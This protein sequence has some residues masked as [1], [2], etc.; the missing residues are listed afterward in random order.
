MRTWDFLSA[1]NLGVHERHDAAALGSIFLAVDALHR[2]VQLET[3]GRLHLALK[4]LEHIGRVR[5]HPS[6]ALVADVD[7]HWRNVRASRRALAA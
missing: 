2:L 5:E 3:A 7:R 1:E 4:H 6:H